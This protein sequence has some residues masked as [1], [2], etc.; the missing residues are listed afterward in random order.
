MHRTTTAFLDIN[1]NSF[2][3]GKNAYCGCSKYGWRRQYCRYTNQYERGHAKID[4]ITTVL[5]RITT[6]TKIAFLSLSRISDHI[7]APRKNNAKNRMNEWRP[8]AAEE[9]EDLGV[10]SRWTHSFYGHRPIKKGGKIPFFLSFESEGVNCPN[11]EKKRRG[12]NKC[13]SHHR[14]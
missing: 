9:E 12:K 14:A 6:E 3:G 2:R 8:M 4:I 13:L 5:E 11:E 7:F 1:E 10:R